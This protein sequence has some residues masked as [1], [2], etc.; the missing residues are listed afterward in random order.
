MLSKLYASQKLLIHNYIAN[1]KVSINYFNG[2]LKGTFMSPTII[3]G[4]S[5]KH[6]STKNMSG[7]S[8]EF[9]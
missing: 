7:I 2:A 6:P 3:Y 9:T 4:K 1:T 5:L 8:H